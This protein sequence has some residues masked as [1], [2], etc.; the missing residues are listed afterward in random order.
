LSI[1]TGTFEVMTEE[2]HLTRSVQSTAV[3]NVTGAM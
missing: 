1:Y 3:S 2:L